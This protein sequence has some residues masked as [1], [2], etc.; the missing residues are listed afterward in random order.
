VERRALRPLRAPPRHLLDRRPPTV[1][2]LPA[3]ERTPRFWD[4]PEVFDP[5]RFTLE[6]EAAWHPYAYSPFGADPR[7]CIGSHFAILEAAI[8]VAVLLQRFRI[9][10]QLEDVPLDSEGITLRPKGAVPIRLGPR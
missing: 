6:R 7:A 5:T 4:N 2:D 8:A 9:D 10:S 3:L 1:D